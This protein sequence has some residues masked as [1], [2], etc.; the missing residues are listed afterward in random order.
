MGVSKTVSRKAILD[1]N[2][3]LSDTTAASLARPAH[4]HRSFKRPKPVPRSL[5]PINAS[6]QQTG[7][8]LNLNGDGNSGYDDSI[9]VLSGSTNSSIELSA[10]SRYINYTIYI[11]HN[12]YISMY[13]YSFVWTC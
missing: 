5:Q 11:I 3:T 1:M 7:S 8:G 9:S 12:I 4:H 10:P 13:M 2:D 6:Q